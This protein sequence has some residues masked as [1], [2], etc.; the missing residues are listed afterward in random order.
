MRLSLADASIDI[1]ITKRGE[2]IVA[3]LGE[4]HLENALRDLA[5]VYCEKEIKINTS[6]PIVEFGEGTTY[7]DFEKKGPESVRKAWIKT[8]PLRQVTITPYCD[9]D[10]IENAKLGRCRAMIAGKSGSISFRVLPLSQ[11]LFRYIECI[12]RNSTNDNGEIATLSDELLLLASL[13][14]IP[15]VETCEDKESKLS[16]I[17]RT[18]A[19]LSCAYDTNGCNI[20]IQSKRVLDGDAI[21]GVED[22]EV[23]HP[24]HDVEEENSLTNTN[25]DSVSYS[26]YQQMK[27]ISL[28]LPSMAND[29]NEAEKKPIH[30]EAHQIWKTRMLGS[31][32]AGFQAAMRSGPLCEEHIRG[33]L[34]I[35]EGIEIAL[36]K[37]QD[38]YKLSKP[39]GGGMVLSAT[40]QGIRC[41]FLSRPARLVEGY[42]KLSLHSS[43]EG[44]GP[45]YNILSKR[46]GRVVEDTMVDGTQLLLIEALLPQAEAFGLT[47]ELLL[48][49]SGN[50]TAPEMIFSHYEILDEDPFWIPS[51]LE[52][53][54]DFGEIISSGDTST[55]VVK[56]RGLTY[57]RKMRRRKGLV[58][59]EE[60]ILKDGEKQ[61]TL[62]RKK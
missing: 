9:E 36:K 41:A 26:A 60:K 48:R 29:G 52:E 24:V 55:G 54:E 5:H 43:L 57:L 44:L 16:S 56:H 46:R 31:A 32:I 28:M 34:V 33:V 2:T 45:L 62:A 42:F 51:S 23:Y 21:L 40:R 39:I 22:N 58:I 37:V 1:T 35:I 50:V 15:E 17:I 49:S 7:F 61:R 14:E 27:N 12:S 3:A 13:L 38:S 30:L 6:D 10:G 25:S 8:P 18:I 11:S 4:L 19:E 20:M 47:Q 59:D 53:R